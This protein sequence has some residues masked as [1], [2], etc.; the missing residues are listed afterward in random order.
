VFFSEFVDDSGLRDSS[1]GFGVQP[2]WPAMMPLFYTPIDHC[3][4]S[5]N[6]VIHGR[7]TGPDLGSDHL[8]VVVEFSLLD[9]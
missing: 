5:E 3:L 2:S 7:Q 1:R 6:V 9:E 4:V 8:P